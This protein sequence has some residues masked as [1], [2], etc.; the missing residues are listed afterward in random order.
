MIPVQTRFAYSDLAPDTRSIVEAATDRLHTLERKTGE[1]I[2]EMGQELIRVKQALGHGLFGAWLES[3]FGWTDRTAQNFMNVAEKF[4]GKTENFAHFA[5][6]AL[7]ALASG[8][9][10]Q[11]IRDEFTA[12]AE[13]GERVTH[14]DVKHRLSHKET[15]RIADEMRKPTK[16][17]GA[18]IE[19]TPR[20]SDDEP[21]SDLPHDV[22]DPYTG[23]ILESHPD[24][25]LSPEPRPRP[26]PERRPAEPGDSLERRAHAV[27]ADLIA[28]HGATQAVRIAHAILT[29]TGQRS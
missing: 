17:V 3:E 11:E 16:R 10:P 18:D 12:K 13:A 23:E 25:S 7:Y 29:Q 1:Q 28:G 24:P 20:L 19:P 26:A 9:V 5:P 21:L 6:S 4:A 22:V 14:Q 2:I 15:Q 8:S 27:A